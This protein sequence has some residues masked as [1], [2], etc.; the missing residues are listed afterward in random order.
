M[1]GAAPVFGHP[2]AARA[3]GERLLKPD[4]DDRQRL[5]LV[6]AIVSTAECSTSPSIVVPSRML[7][8]PA[9]GGIGAKGILTFWRTP[10]HV[11]GGIA[12]PGFAITVSP[13]I[14]AQH[15]KAQKRAAA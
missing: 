3:L 13:M 4:I 5:T 14:G 1:R 11:D 15:R 2:V 8:L 9:L 6:R 7:D 10:V 12:E